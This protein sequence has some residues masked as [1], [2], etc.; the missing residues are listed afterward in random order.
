MRKQAD[1]LNDVADR[2]PQANRIPLA[3][4]SALH[5]HVARVG[6]EQSIDQLEHGRLARAARADQ[7]DHFAG[8]DGEGERIEHGRLPTVPE[9]HLTELD[10]D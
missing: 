3:R 1:V 9:R 10:T 2:S 5:A 6:Q 7:R 4:V 8:V